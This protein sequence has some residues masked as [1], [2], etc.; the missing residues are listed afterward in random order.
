MYDYMQT[1]SF[2]VVQ[3]I[4]TM[5][6]T[7]LLRTTIIFVPFA[8]LLYYCLLF[9]IITYSQEVAKYKTDLIYLL[10]FVIVLLLYWEYIVTFV[11][12]LLI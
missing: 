9:K 5:F 6:L 11:N 4:F 8:L 2:I 12:V 7:D 10:K 1:F 3:T